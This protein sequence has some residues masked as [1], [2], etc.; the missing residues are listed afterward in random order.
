ML[1]HANYQAEWCNSLVSFHHC[2]GTAGE[3]YSLWF[4]IINQIDWVL[5]S[6]NKG[7]KST[8]V[9]GQASA[10]ERKKQLGFLSD[11]LGGAFVFATVWCVWG[12][13][14]DFRIGAASRSWRVPL[15][16]PDVLGHAPDR[17]SDLTSL[18]GALLVLTQTLLPCGGFSEG[19]RAFALDLWG[20]SS[21]WTERWCSEV[22]GTSVGIG[23]R[24]SSVHPERIS[25]F[26]LRTL[27]L[28]L[29]KLI[30]LGQFT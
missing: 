14:E 7:C 8:E 13:E 17:Q 12:S 22:D 9:C 6:L 25:R 27:T 3:C 10:W 2:L 1:A 19:V 5:A 30:D 16:T 28:P 11:C 23:G 15:I 21:R 24:A 4:S 18:W 29:D 26:P 20:Q